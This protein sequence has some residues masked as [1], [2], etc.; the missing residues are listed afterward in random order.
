MEPENPNRRRAVVAVII[1]DGKFL[2]IT[3][4]ETVRAPGKICF[5]GG[6]VE[7]NESD[8]DALKRE[9]T[10]ELNIEGDPG[11]LVYSNRSPWGVQ[12]RWWTF[13]MREG[14]TP[15]PNPEEVASVQWMT[16]LEM[17][18]HPNLLT[19]NIVFLDTISC[20]E[21]SFSGIETR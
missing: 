12:L 2:T 20:G 4:S 1:R 17:R 7:Q 21:L 11:E 15:V 6:S 10:E 14:Q 8:E 13:E 19:S 5:P 18:R 3:R 16:F 9:L